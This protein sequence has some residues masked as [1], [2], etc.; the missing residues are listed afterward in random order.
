M[1][2]PIRVPP[3]L[4]MKVTSQGIS[5]AL[6]QLQ[7]EGDKESVKLLTEVQKNQIAKEKADAERAKTEADIRKLDQE[8]ARQ[9][10]ENL[11]SFEDRYSSQM[12]GGLFSGGTKGVLKSGAKAVTGDP[13]KAR[14]DAEAKLAGASEGTGRPVGAS[15]AGEAMGGG[16]GEF[17][18]PAPIQLQEGPGISVPAMPEA[19]DTTAYE[20]A[21]DD[22]RNA[23]SANMGRI[24]AQMEV[25]ERIQSAFREEG[26][27]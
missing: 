8:T 14:R 26:V 3:I 19:L 16:I 17:Q 13:D 27:R 15:S 7:Q 11:A 20:E 23:I 22:Q 2:Q 4:S 12:Q 6:N 25:R 10:A 21:L 9:K 5:R 1:A 18:P 24:D